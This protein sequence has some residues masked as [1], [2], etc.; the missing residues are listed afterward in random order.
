M[1]VSTFLMNTVVRLLVIGYGAHL[2]FGSAMDFEK[3]SRFV[4]F[5]DML[6]S[7]TNMLFD[8][9]SNLV[10]SGGASA[11]VFDILNREGGRGGRGWGE[12]EG[13]EPMAAPGHVSFENVS[14]S[15]PARPG[16]AVLRGV[17]FQAEAGKTLAIIGRSGSGKSTIVNLIENFYQPDVGRVLLDGKSVAALGHEE[18]HSAVAIVNQDTVLFSGSI[19]DNIVYGARNE[20]VRRGWRGKELMPRVVEAARVANI[21]DFI[22]TLPG[23][24]D[25][26][27]GERGVQLSGGQRQRIAI[28]RAVLADPR[29][30]RLDEAT[31]SLDHESEKAVKEALDRVMDGKTVVVVAHRLST[32]MNAN[33]ILVMRDGEIA[34]QGP[35]ERMQE[36]LKT[37]ATDMEIVD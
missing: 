35:P 11:K 28:A 31:S 13:A 15:Y 22:S 36:W 26:E 3:L 17:T 9:F 27:V 8:S 19:Y 2:Y 18:L 20:A 23:G 24:Y 37:A 30:L 25:E 4:F 6:Q 7:W 12:G 14:F 29:V 33:S 21:H 5:V 32:I 16:E 34:D 10:K 1:L